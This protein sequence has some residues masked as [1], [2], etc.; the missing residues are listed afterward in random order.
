MYNIGMYKLCKNCTKPFY[1]KQHHSKSYWN[2]IATYCSFKCSRIVSGR[3]PKPN[4]Y[5]VFE[6]Y[7]VI[8]VN[9]KGVKYDSKIDKSDYENNS[10]SGYSWSLSFDNRYLQRRPTTK[11]GLISLHHLVLPKKEGFVVDHIN[12]DSLDNRGS[13]LRYLTFANNIRNQKKKTYK[14]GCAG[15]RK[16]GKKYTARIGRLETSR[17]DSLEEAISKRIELE[18]ENWGISFTEERIKNT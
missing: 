16:V 10:I 15:V 4:D 1:K 5:D 9:K 2:N 12:G 13:N 18:K 6:D 14:Y 11:S 8:R 3:K 7:V 17:Y